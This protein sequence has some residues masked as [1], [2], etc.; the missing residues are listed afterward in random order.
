[1][2][3]RTK[4]RLTYIVLA[5]AVALLIAALVGVIVWADAQIQ[6]EHGRAIE[7]ESELADT[8]AELDMFQSTLKNL[9]EGTQDLSFM[10]G[11]SEE[12]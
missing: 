4:D 2:T 10:R 12:D 1:M 3:N 5:L 7:L 11:P 6:R 9:G 8:R